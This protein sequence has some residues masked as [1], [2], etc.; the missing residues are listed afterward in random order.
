MS[1]MSDL[2]EHGHF[3]RN[4]KRYAVCE[5]CGKIVCLDKA[6]FGSFHFCSADEEKGEE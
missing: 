2:K 6:F 1:E 3:I 4:G 5:E